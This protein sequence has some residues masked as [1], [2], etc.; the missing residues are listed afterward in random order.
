MQCA[1]A[2]LY[3]YLWPFWLYHIFPR[4]LTNGTIFEK[5]NIEYETCVLIFSTSFTE[6]F[7]IL[8]RIQR[9]TIGNVLRFSCKAHVTFVRF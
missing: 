7:L 3:C 4:Y 9:D 1:C 6:T 5:K 8:R 2:V